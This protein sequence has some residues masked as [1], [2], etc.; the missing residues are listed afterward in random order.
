[1]ARVVQEQY[2]FNADPTLRLILF[3]E[4][5]EVPPKLVRVQAT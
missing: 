1:M 3:L 4:Q 5:M 2:S